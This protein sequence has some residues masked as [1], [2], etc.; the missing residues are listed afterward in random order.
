[1]THDEALLKAQAMW[2]QRE[3][4]PGRSALQSWG[5]VKEGI[6]FAVGIGIYRFK[7]DDCEQVDFHCKGFGATWEQ[8][9]ERAARPAKG[10]HP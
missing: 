6:V 8:A 3:V 4:V 2:P 9:F 7:D 10:V 1:M 5:A